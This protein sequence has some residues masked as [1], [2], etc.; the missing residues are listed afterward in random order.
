MRDETG[1]RV[2]D[3]GR[4]DSVEVDPDV[5]TE[6]GERFAEVVGEVFEE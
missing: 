1:S 2:A 5:L 3:D 4:I 6:F